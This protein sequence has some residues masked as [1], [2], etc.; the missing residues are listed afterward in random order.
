MKT[1]LAFAGLPIVALI[2]N[3]AVRIL[4]PAH[5]NTKIVLRLGAASTKIKGHYPPLGPVCRLFSRLMDGG[6]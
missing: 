4:F 2:I 3:L 6:L 1:D 5:S